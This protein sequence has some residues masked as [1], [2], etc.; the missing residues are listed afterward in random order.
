MYTME[1]LPFKNKF[2]I[3]PSP[4]PFL[5]YIK[6]NLPKNT[7]ITEQLFFVYDLTLNPTAVESV[8]EKYLQ[9]FYLI[10]FLNF[11]RHDVIS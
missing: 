11:S 2:I 3:A 7:P 4:L 9:Q 1:K 8:L 10:I 6:N 5:L